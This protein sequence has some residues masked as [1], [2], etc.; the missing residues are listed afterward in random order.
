MARNDVNGNFALT[1]LDVLST[2][3]MMLGEEEFRKA[4]GRVIKD[5]YW[6]NVKVQVFEG[7]FY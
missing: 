2:L 7:E 3:P 4:V 6:G 1:H 5:T